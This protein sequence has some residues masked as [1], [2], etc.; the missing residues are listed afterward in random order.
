VT[1]ATRTCHFAARTA[2][3]FSIRDACVKPGVRLVMLR[4]WGCRYFFDTLRTGVIRSTPL[5]RNPWVPMFS[6]SPSLLRNAPAALLLVVVACLTPDRASAGCGNHVPLFTDPL[7]L[8]EQKANTNESS[9]APCT[10]PDCLR[11]ANESRPVPPCH[12][13]GCSQQPTRDA[14]APTASRIVSPTT[15]AA[16]NAVSSHCDSTCRVFPR[17]LSS[18]HPIARPSSVFHPPRHV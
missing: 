9:P 15:D 16:L 5:V 1:C 10:G 8:T 12:G 13:P 4:V 18:L 3:R 7:P 17:D 2:S 11:Q 6:L 14:P